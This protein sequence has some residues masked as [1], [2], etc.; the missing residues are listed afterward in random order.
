[1]NDLIN[2]IFFN[3]IVVQKEKRN[4]TDMTEINIINESYGLI[5]KYFKIIFTK[6]MCNK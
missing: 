3:I 1:M 4:V 6:I 2:G 5:H